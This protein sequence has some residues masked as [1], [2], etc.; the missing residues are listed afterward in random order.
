MPTM[1][2]QYIDTAKA[3]KIIGVTIQHIGKMIDAGTLYAKKI[4]RDWHV[5]LAS[6]E[7]A[8]KNP[9]KVGRPRGKKTTKLA[10]G[11]TI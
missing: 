2:T 10:N 3:A 7:R 4:G 5:T 1:A 6:V 8:R 9:S 11:I